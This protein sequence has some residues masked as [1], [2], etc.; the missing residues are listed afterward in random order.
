MTLTDEQREALRYVREMIQR[1]PL[2]LCQDAVSKR[3]TVMIRVA[4][5]TIDA[6]TAEAT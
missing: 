1:N 4:T 3:H 6:L 5:A 2:E